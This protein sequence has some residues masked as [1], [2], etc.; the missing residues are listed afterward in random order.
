MTRPH[1][2]Q[3][4]CYFSGNVDEQAH[5]YNVMQLTRRFWASY[6]VP[7]VEFSLLRIKSMHEKDKS[8]QYHFMVS[9]GITTKLCVH[10][11]RSL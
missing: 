4:M 2:L 8:V 7:E 11:G 5:G 1:P 10:S 3:G 6:L 9:K